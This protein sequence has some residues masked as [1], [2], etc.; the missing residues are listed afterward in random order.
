MKHVSRVA[1]CAE[2]HQVVLVLQQDHIVILQT[3]CA[4]AQKLSILVVE[5]QIPVLMAFANVEPT[6]NVVMMEKPVVRDL[7][8]AELFQV[9]LECPLDHFVISQTV[10]VNVQRLSILAV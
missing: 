1:A 5:H 6:M 3:V 10:S 4:N 2:R 9:V 8:C 7:A